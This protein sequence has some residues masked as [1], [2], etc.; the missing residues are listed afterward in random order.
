MKKI[1]ILTLQAFLFLFTTTSLCQELIAPANGLTF[2][3]IEATTA[4]IY[5]GGLNAQVA[6]YNLTDTNFQEEIVANG[7]GSNHLRFNLDTVNNDV[8]LAQFEGPIKSAPVITGNAS[9]LI[10]L[11]TFEIETLGV[12]FY[13]GWV[14]A[15]TTAPQIFRFMPDDPDNTAQLILDPASPLPF[16][17]IHLVDGFL[18]YSTQSSFSNPIDYQVFRLDISVT[19]PTPELVTTTPDRI[20]SI[21][22]IGE[23]LY[24][25]SDESATVYK[26]SIISPDSNAP[27]FTTLTTTADQEA[28]SITHNGQHLYYVLNGTNGGIFRIADE[29]LSINQPEYIG[30][31]IF[32][33]PTTD[34]LMISTNDSLGGKK[35]TVTNV[36]GQRLL[37]NKIEDTSIDISSLPAGI[38][39]LTIEQLKTMRFI[40]N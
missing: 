22:S 30:L 13:E 29:V 32:P 10:N 34:I 19:N 18:Y 40:K 4:Y 3:E 20:W 6:R 17:N 31:K 23:F 16:F 1:Y 8:Y 11:G 12:Q 15:M 2:G 38:Y 24:L 14:Y 36:Q 35:Y 9:T 25:L 7:A 21:T 27:I 26:T 39:F 33:N 5:R 28:F 37:E